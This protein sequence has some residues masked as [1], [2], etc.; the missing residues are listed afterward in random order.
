MM[1]LGTL[2]GTF[3]EPIA[4]NNQ[5]AVV[6]SLTL[7]PDDHI[8]HATLWNG[9]QVFDLGA[10]GPDQCS[11]ASAVNARGKWLDS[12]VTAHST[13]PLYAQ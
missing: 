5:G 10:L 2:G 1:D 3:A 7:P 13:I 9:G 4:I 12:P 8:F 6:G 11:L